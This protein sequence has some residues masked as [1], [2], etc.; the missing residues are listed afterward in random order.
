MKGE[1]LCIPCTVRTALDIAVKATEDKELQSKLVYETMKWLVET[2]DVLNETPAML[3]THVQRL[4]EKITGA[5][6]PFKDLKKASNEIALRVVPVLEKKCVQL[7][8]A[9]AFR[10]AV[11]GTICGNAIDFEVEEHRFSMDELESSLLLCLNGDL[12][13]D[14]T[15]KLNEALSKSKKVV[16]LLDNA[17][18]I[19]FDKF[20]MR[21]ITSHFSVNV[22][23]AVKNG[24]ILND[25]TMEDAE[26]VRLEEV[27][28]V[29]TTGN[30]HI[31]VNLDESSEDFREHLRTADLIIAKGQ[32]NYESLTEVEHLFPKPIAY[33]LKAKCSLV[34]DKLGI[35]RNGNVVKIIS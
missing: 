26:Q 16:Y 34:A 22:Y 27:A 1:L 24:P 33:I 6:D 19:V 20:F 11:L 12:V 10:L 4:A 25:T 17:G 13:I 9:D 8:F 32:G 5:T 7:K 18:E 2:P 31:G 29:I 21:I 35:P 14:D 3:H 15:V 28:E 30:D 23:A